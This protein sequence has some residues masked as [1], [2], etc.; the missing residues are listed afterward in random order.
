MAQPSGAAIQPAIREALAVHGAKVSELHRYVQVVQRTW[1][2]LQLQ[3]C[4]I[5]HVSESLAEGET[6]AHRDAASTEETVRIMLCIVTAEVAEE[7][8][9]SKV[10]LDAAPL[11]KK[12][13]R[14]EGHGASRE[15]LARAQVRTHCYC[16]A[17]PEKW[18]L[19]TSL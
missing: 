5:L 19:S 2:E 17:V 16:I 4:D 9:D 6:A 1:E 10:T 12:R 11:A 15:L 14:Q 13:R 8:Q 18:C 3:V 7:T